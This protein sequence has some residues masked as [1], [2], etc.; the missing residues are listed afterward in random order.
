MDG[1]RF[2]FSQMSNARRRGSPVPKF[3][4]HSRPKTDLRAKHKCSDFST[5]Y[6]V[7]SQCSIFLRGGRTRSSCSQFPHRLYSPKAQPE[8]TTVKKS[9]ILQQA[10]LVFDDGDC[11]G[12][13]E[14]HSGGHLAALTNGKSPVQPACPAS[15]AISRFSRVHPPWAQVWSWTRPRIQV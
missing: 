15:L 13:D 4:G 7:Q 9:Q 6:W 8:K 12:C 2:P 11:D 14:Q 1:N 5:L 10:A 3:R